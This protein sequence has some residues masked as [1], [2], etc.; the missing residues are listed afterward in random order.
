MESL[1][2]P[3]P[4]S[5][6]LSP[7]PS[8]LPPP[9]DDKYQRNLAVYRDGINENLR[10]YNEAIECLNQ[11]QY[12]LRCDL[13]N[14]DNYIAGLNINNACGGY[15]H[16]IMRYYTKK[17]LDVEYALWI[18]TNEIHKHVEERDALGSLLVRVC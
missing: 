7:S 4:L 6:S 5:I 11:R 8:P 9:N 14:M 10:A 2:L 13:H 12:S 16:D 15:Q 1:S 3:L 18:I 17:R